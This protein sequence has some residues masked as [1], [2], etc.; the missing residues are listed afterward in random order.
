MTEYQKVFKSFLSKIRKDE[1]FYNYADQE[2]EDDMISIMN[3]AIPLFRYPRENLLNKDDETEMFVADL[4]LDTISV[5]TDFMKYEWYSR[6]AANSDTLDQRLVTKNL[7]F[8]SQANHIDAL[9]K[10]VEQSRKMARENEE[11]YYKAVKGKPQMTGLVGD[12]I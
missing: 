2:L 8:Y 3:N 7:T 12:E 4:E 1:D 6:R 5:L 11:R 10:I 9:N